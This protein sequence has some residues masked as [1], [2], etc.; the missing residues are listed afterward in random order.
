[1]PWGKLSCTFGPTTRWSRCSYSGTTAAPCIHCF[2]TLVT[3]CVEATLKTTCDALHALCCA[4]ARAPTSAQC[5]WV[6]NRAR[7]RIASFAPPIQARALSSLHSS[8][9]KPGLKLLLRDILLLVLN[10]NAQCVHYIS[11]EHRYGLIHVG[12]HHVTQVSN[13]LRKNNLLT[14]H[15][16]RC[17]LMLMWCV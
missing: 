12:P 8:T 17:R 16:I 6:Q 1:M 5:C 4:P 3:C 10:R 2:C 11:S 7:A 9:A 13:I 14:F 15:K